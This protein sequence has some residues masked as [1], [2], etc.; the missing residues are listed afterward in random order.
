V[1]QAFDAT[2]VPAR[3]KTLDLDLRSKLFM[4]LGTLAL[5]VIAV[6]GIALLGIRQIGDQLHEAAAVRL[7]STAQLGALADLTASYRIEQFQYTLAPESERAGVELS[8]AATAAAV[9]ARRDAY[10]Q[11]LVHAKDREDLD[12]FGKAWEQYLETQAQVHKMMA[13]G[14]PLQATDLLNGEA[15]VAFNTVRSVVDRMSKAN[16]KAA[17]ELQ[18]R[19]QEQQRRAVWMIGLTVLVA[20][21]LGILVGGSVA[22]RIATSVQA[23]QRTASE[24]AEGRLDGVV[25]VRG[26]DEIG[27]LL[28]ALDDMRRGL[29]GIVGNARETAEAVT[30]AMQEIAAANDDLSTRTDAEASLLQGL[31]S[32]LAQLRDTAAG[33]A[34]DA[35]DAEALCHH[36]REAVDQTTQSSRE[37]CRRM[38]EARASARQIV[39]ILGL[40]DA[41]AHKTNMLAL[42]AAVE[43]ARAGEHGRG[44]AVVAAE[45]RT[46]AKSSADAAREIRQL[47]ESSERSIKGSAELASATESAMGRLG[48]TIGATADKVTQIARGSAEQS[49]EVTRMA[50]S[51]ETLEHGT[52]RNAALVQQMAASSSSIHLQA[53]QLA[54]TM[55]TFRIADNDERVTAELAAH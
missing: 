17:L 43:A 13:D 30:T 47:V 50:N 27:R 4:A 23:A 22:R 25:A 1:N 52:Q 42:N 51:L 21:G 20:S 44:F 32:S 26:N 12:A 7:P 5:A 36:A 33:N 10:R 29:A 35:G 11:L 14:L 38:D 53:Q 45:V 6:G 55:R 16:A 39:E 46:L 8:L 15:K 34:G 19:S 37:L 28:G 40:I 49:G 54:E 2:P 3:R 48:T 18:H 24:I 9:A 31:V 41:V